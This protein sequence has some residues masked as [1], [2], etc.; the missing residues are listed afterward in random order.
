MVYFWINT[1]TLSKSNTSVQ[2]GVQ[3]VMGS[4]LVWDL[5]NKP[6]VL[7]FILDQKLLRSLVSRLSV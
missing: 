7:I 4:I 2:T 5:G 1:I 3:N 6:K